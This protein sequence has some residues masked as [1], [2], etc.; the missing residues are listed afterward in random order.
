MGM[1]NFGVADG[2]CLNGTIGDL[3]K[4]VRQQVVAE[5]MGVIIK[6]KHWKVHFLDILGESKSALEK[7]II[8]LKSFSNQ[9]KSF[10]RQ[11][12]HTRFLETGDN[13]YLGMELSPGYQN[14]KTKTAKDIS[15]SHKNKKVKT[16]AFR[17]S[18]MSNIDRL[19]FQSCLD[20]IRD[21][22]VYDPSARR[23]IPAF[24]LI[25]SCVDEDLKE[26]EI[27]EA[28]RWAVRPTEKYEVIVKEREF[29]FARNI[30][31][32]V[33]KLKADTKVRRESD[34]TRALD[35]NMESEIAIT[36]F[37]VEQFVSHRT[38]V[39]NN[40]SEDY[41]FA[42]MGE[43][44]ATSHFMRS[45]QLTGVGVNA[46]IVNNFLKAASDCVPFLDRLKKF[47]TETDGS[48]GDVV[49]SSISS[50]YAQ[51][52]FLRLSFPHSDGIDFL[53]AKVT[54]CIESD[55]DTKDVLSVDWKGKFSSAMIP[56][57]ME[58]NEKYAD[59]LFEQ[60]RD[61]LIDKFIVGVEKDK[62]ISSERLVNVLKDR[63]KAM[64][65]FD[66]DY[67]NAKYYWK[68]FLSGLEG[69]LTNKE[70]AELE[71]YHCKIAKKAEQNVIKIV[72]F[73]KQESLY[74]ARVPSEFYNQPKPADYIANSFSL[75]A[76][77]ILYAISTCAV[78]FCV[79]LALL[80][81]STEAGES[82]AMILGALNIFFSFAIII[83]ASRYKTRVEE[84][85]LLLFEEKVRGIQKVLF[86]LMNEASRMKADPKKNPFATELEERVQKFRADAGYYN[87]PKPKELLGEFETLKRKINNPVAIR[88]FK[89]RLA[90]HYIA[91]VY[92]KNSVLQDSLVEIFKVFDDMY[93][94]YTQ[95]PEISQSNSENA[96]TLLR[97]L[98]RFTPRLEKS[99]QAGHFYWGFMKHRRFVHWNF[100]VVMRS[101]FGL[102]CC[103]RAGGA[104]PLAP[105]QTEIY[106]IY[107]GVLSLSNKH[108]R[109]VLQREAC[110][111]RNLHHATR[112]SNVAS[113]IY[114]L[115]LI[116]N[117]TSWGFVITRILELSMD[118]GPL[119]TD[120]S[121]W[122]TLS[123]GLAI[124]VTAPRLVVNY[125]IVINV[126]WKLWGSTRKV[127]SGDTKH[128]NRAAFV[129]FLQIFHVFFRIVIAMAACITLA[130]HI[131]LHSFS[132]ILDTQRNLYSWI[133]VKDNA[134]YAALGTAGLW[135]LTNLFSMMIDYLVQYNLSPRLGEYI[136]DSFRDDLRVIYRIMSVSINDTE[137][138]IVQERA[139]WE[140]VAQEFLHK[141]RFD[142]VFST[143]RYGSILQFIQ[144]GMESRARARLSTRGSVRLSTST[145]GQVIIPSNVVA[146]DIV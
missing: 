136:C 34:L 53:H 101:F 11:T 15:K 6:T 47:C 118:V 56:R 108:E 140:Y 102:F 84:L 134:L 75:E 143:E 32:I 12:L 36:T 98:R 61:H 59:S 25:G 92:Q 123:T 19:W 62:G 133:A 93:M 124:L 95:G 106:G 57:G 2:N 45:D 64:K 130:W 113:I 63:K 127:R 121:Y 7:L 79:G 89:D 55:R 72:D 66:K 68:D 49:S 112:A 31:G 8:A 116:I 73:A 76:Q 78:F 43:E 109:K 50:N 142:V 16:E 51:D 44:Q 33:V 81:T 82:G 38:F 71:D 117:L 119:V 23:R 67:D 80:M 54:E 65:E 4:M 29:I 20:T 126:W 104:T 22:N 42:F 122:A 87:F 120:L 58:L 85:C 14:W 39:V 99:L 97:R 35:G 26:L 5:G 74:N 3:S 83:N 13:Y 10:R 69:D 9:T 128:V 52:G 100:F 18:I 46:V 141:N 131:I 111:L 37:S 103:A 77:Q 146:V 135:V 17:E 129:A 28:F 86:G 137:P 145:T 41:I 27:G 125:F 70:M 30:F 60:I 21:A 94:T 105:I 48:N 139:T 110:D 1:H 40:R 90:G 88:D 114:V 96:K 107:K 132:D 115:A 91:D 138:K 24:N 144:S